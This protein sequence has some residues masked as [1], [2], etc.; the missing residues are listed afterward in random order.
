MALLSAGRRQQTRMNLSDSQPQAQIPE[1]A[2]SPR[3]LS[4]IQT[5]GIPKPQLRS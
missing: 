5:S 1:S 3:P 4:P 2:E